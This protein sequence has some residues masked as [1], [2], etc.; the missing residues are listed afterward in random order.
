MQRRR[1][2]TSS[3][4]SRLRNDI[5]RDVNCG[6][7]G[8]VSEAVCDPEGRYGGSGMEWSSRVESPG[9]RPASWVVGETNKT[10]TD[11]NTKKKQCATNTHLVRKGLDVL[12]DGD[13]AGL[14]SDLLDAQA[15]VDH[16]ALFS[17]YHDH[18][19]KGVFP[20]EMIPNH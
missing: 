3:P 9:Q 8:R 18:T 1:R 7:D 14:D 2:T 19:D 12:W 5:S 16:L 20:S 4:R 10:K 15:D 13:I 17:L 6:L 11:D